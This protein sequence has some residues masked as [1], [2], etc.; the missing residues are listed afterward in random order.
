MLPGSPPARSA[1]AY[2]RGTDATPEL[3]RYPRLRAPSLL[4]ELQ[5]HAERAGKATT[6][7]QFV[8][9]LS[10]ILGGPVAPLAVAVAA[11]GAITAVGYARELRQAATRRSL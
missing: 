10:A 2:P 4:R 6:V 9:V 8:A 11:L 7:L 3:P 1:Q 5:P